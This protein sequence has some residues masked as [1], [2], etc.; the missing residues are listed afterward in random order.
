MTI[1]LH[2]PETLEQLKPHLSVREY[3]KAVLL[4]N[5]IIRATKALNSE[6]SVANRKNLKDAEEAHADFFGPLVSRYLQPRCGGEDFHQPSERFDSRA[7]ALRWIH[8]QGGKCSVGKFSK[9]CRSGKV[10]VYPDKSVSRASVAEYLLRLQRPVA[11]LDLV[12]HSRTKQALECRRLELEVAKLERAARHDDKRWMRYE[13][14][15]AQVAALL[16]M[17]RENLQ[18]HGQQAAVELALLCGGAPERAPLLVDRLKELIVNPAYN[19]LAGQKIE[20]AV[21]AEQA[22]YAEPGPGED[23]DERQ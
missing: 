8:A 9:D 13:D 1:D 21:F 14:H 10:I 7:E 3:Q 16:V 6:S 12:D 22:E 17:L 2:A 4:S 15:C 19:D 20:Q 18:H 5:D 23:S 11:E